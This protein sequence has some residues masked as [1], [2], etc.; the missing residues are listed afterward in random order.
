MYGRALDGVLRLVLRHAVPVLVVAAVSVVASLAFTARNFHINSDTGTLIRQDAPFRAQYE[1][2]HEAFPQLRETT[3]VVVSG[4]SLEAVSDATARLA[5]RLRGEPEMFS[6]VFAASE[7]EYFFDHILLYL[8]V[9]ELEQVID[10]IFEAQPAITSLSRD[11]SLRGVFELVG[12]GLEQLHA[13]G[14]LTPS[15]VQFMDRLTRVGDAVLDGQPATASWVDELFGSPGEVH[16]LVLV[17][18]RGDFTQHL[19]HER[20][21]DGIRD[22]ADE[23]GIGDGDGLR[24]EI[25]GQF[26]L[27]HEEIASAR[28]GVEVAGAVSFVLLLLVLG[29]GVRSAR[30]VAATFATL[31]TGLSWTSAF[32]LV[33]VGEFNVISVTF[34][35]LFVGLGVDIAIH[36]CLRLQEELEQGAPVER[37]L[38]G[39]AA[40][41]GGAVSLCAVTSGV[42]FLSFVPTQYRG[43]AELGVIAGAGMLFA[44]VS[45]FTV[46]PALLK[47]LHAS[48]LPARPARGARRTLSTA[49]VNDHAVPVLVVASVLAVAS[50]SVATRMDF[51]F[52]T[53]ALKDPD[54]ES[55]RALRILQDD[56]ETTAYSMT[57]LAENRDAVA[58]LVGRLEEL[59][60]VADVRTPDDHVPA[61]QQLKLEILADAYFILEPLLE[62]AV[63]GDAPSDAEQVSALEALQSRVTSI[64]ADAP[65][66]ETR[67]ALVRM[68][69]LLERLHDEPGARASLEARLLEGFDGKVAWLRTALDPGA[70]TFDS[71]PVALRDRLVAADG[72]ARVVALPRD[73]LRDVTSLRRF[74]DA[75]TTV[76]PGATGLPAVEAGVG[77]IVVASFQQALLIALLVI[78]GIL[79]F[80]LRSVVETALA[81]VPLLLGGLLTVATGVMLG[82]PFNMANVVVL[83]LLVGIGVDNG[84]HVLTRYRDGRSLSSLLGS[85]TPRAVVLSAL[86]TL[87][88]FGSLALSPHRG[89]RSVGVLL[90]VSMIYLLLA[91]VVVLPALI[92]WRS[93]RRAA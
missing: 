35:V 25:T 11:P 45:S 80:T 82:M 83:P 2:L 87:S 90:T 44:L 68:D 79:L 15:M 36:Y 37:A 50:A 6:S 24:V 58:A 60:E 22:A 53:L 74:V 13:E 63:V 86:T 4:S 56:G 88:A 16:Q 40:A 62:T 10:R 30:I 52:S 26:A 64:L 9:D 31:V 42:G 70:V 73:D 17:Q 78:V 93:Q 20:V 23:V 29:Y 76:A 39:A 1:L 19:A 34:A 71:L 57:V 66:G 8:D 91:T 69:A 77:A 81:L 89:I 46:L 21:F 72:R 65:G 48:G 38:L 12:S 67:D 33:T 43:L 92:A 32:A 28:R 41:V 47:V 54:S 51:D 85:S 84:I 59:P 55:M 14:G 75:V 27:E 49:W 61:D 18:G 5:R 3:L 7:D